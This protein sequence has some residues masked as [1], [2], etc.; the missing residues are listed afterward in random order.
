[1]YLFTLSPNSVSEVVCSPFSRLEQTECITFHLLEKISLRLFL[2]DCSKIDL[3]QSLP[4]MPFLSVRLSSIKHIHFRQPS[5]P[6]IAA[7]FS[8]SQTDSVPIKHQR[9]SPNPS[10]HPS[11]CSLNST[12][13]GPS[14][15]WN[16]AT[17]AL[18]DWLI[19]LS[20]MPSRLIHVVAC[21]NRLPF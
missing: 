21:R 18:C 12:I 17:F 9:H 3:Q 15:K 14:C 20:R 7:T 2:K 5:A 16:H 8:S 4:W 19:P 6:S 10:P 13:L 11:A 1:M